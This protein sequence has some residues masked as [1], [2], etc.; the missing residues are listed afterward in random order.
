MTRS[1]P[2]KAGTKSTSAPC[3]YGHTKHLS[4]DGLTCCSKVDC[5]CTEFRTA[6]SLTEKEQRRFKQLGWLFEEATK[7]EQ[8]NPQKIGEKVLTECNVTEETN[9]IGVW[10]SWSTTTT[11]TTHDG[12]FFGFPL[13]CLLQNPDIKSCYFCFGD[14][15]K[16]TQ[17]QNGHNLRQETRSIP[18]QEVMIQ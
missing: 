18:Q 7:N 5:C 13:G 3:I 2:A 10:T 9:K 1:K 14:N 17:A 15:S 6:S 16:Q 4:S 11:T 8:N 12:A